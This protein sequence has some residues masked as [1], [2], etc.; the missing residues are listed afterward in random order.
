MIKKYLLIL[1]T[2]LIPTALYADVLDDYMSVITNPAIS[3][4]EKKALTVLYG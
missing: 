1:I 3:E 2:I 4:Q